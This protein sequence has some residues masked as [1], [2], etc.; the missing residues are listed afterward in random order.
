MKI[1]KIEYVDNVR[2]K[3]LHNNMIFPMQ[4][5]LRIYFNNNTMRVIDLF[6]EKDTTDIDYYEILN[7]YKTKTKVIME[8]R[9][10]KDL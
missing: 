9:E 4:S 5:I 7:T 1:I 8:D 6:S 2:Y 3:N 10:Y